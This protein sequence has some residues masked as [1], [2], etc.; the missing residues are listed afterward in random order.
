MKHADKNR[1]LAIGIAF[2]PMVWAFSCHAQMPPAVS[3]PPARATYAVAMAVAANGDESAPSNEVSFT[4]RA[5]SLTWTASPSSNVTYV[6]RMGRKSGQW[7]SGEIRA[8]TNCYADYPPPPPPVRIRVT[9]GTNEIFC[10]TN[11][12]GVLMFTQRRTGNWASILASSDC[13]HW[14]NPYTLVPAADDAPLAIE[15]SFLQ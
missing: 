14:T 6:V 3:L 2:W 11:P 1:W 9:R 12:A 5:A 10:A 8:G 13:V 15:R 7:N 4:N